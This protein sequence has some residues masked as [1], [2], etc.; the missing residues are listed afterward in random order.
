[1]RKLVWVDTPETRKAYSRYLAEITYMDGQVGD[2]SYTVRSEP[3][4]ALCLAA[5]P[6]P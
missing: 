5:P 3:V 1:M 2:I 6:A 4:F